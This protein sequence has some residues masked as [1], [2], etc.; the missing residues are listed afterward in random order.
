MEKL[1]ELSGR[2]P[3]GS[4]PIEPGR[5]LMSNTDVANEESF[6]EDGGRR[7]DT[8]VLRLLSK[9][10][11]V[12]CSVWEVKRMREYGGWIRSRMARPN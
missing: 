4:G 6:I 8:R 10:A 5:G 2:A 1:S 12:G 7:S 9:H 3:A 11:R